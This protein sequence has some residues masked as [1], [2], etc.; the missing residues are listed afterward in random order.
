MAVATRSPAKRWGSGSGL[1]ASQSSGSWP[2]AQT[3]FSKSSDTSYFPASPPV[4]CSYLRSDSR[5]L[6]DSPLRRPPARSLAPAK[7]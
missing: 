1:W 4:L 2:P 5:R 7:S 6:S 3:T